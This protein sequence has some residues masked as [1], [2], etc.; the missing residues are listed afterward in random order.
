M[1]PNAASAIGIAR[2]HVGVGGDRAGRRAARIR[3]LDH[4]RR[5][6]GELEHD[7]RGRIEVEQVRV[8]QLLALQHGAPRRAPAPR[9]LGVP[10][11]R[12]DAGFR[13]SA[14]RRTL[15]QAE[16]QRAGA[17]DGLRRRAREAAV[18]R[19]RSA[20]RRG[21]R[22]V[23]APRCARTPCAPARSGT[24]GWARPADRAA[25]APPRSRPATRP[26]ARRGKFLAAARTRLGPPMSISSISASNGVAGFAA[27]ATNG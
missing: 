3:V 8:R 1:P 4:R 16:R 27:A 23:V 21:D 26:R 15:L 12:A 5:R 17:G 18:R 10:G 24:P 20:E 2:A 14:G 9:R 22:G 6:L 7:A 25:R 11:R 13:R 19:A